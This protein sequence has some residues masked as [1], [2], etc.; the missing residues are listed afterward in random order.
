M[1]YY[2]SLLA[3]PIGTLLVV[4]IVATNQKYLTTLM[5]E[6]QTMKE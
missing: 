3:T 2:R 5:E 1:S 4:M 6:V